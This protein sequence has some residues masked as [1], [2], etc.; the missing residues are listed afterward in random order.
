MS[1]EEKQTVRFQRANYMVSNLEQ[2]YKFYCDVLGFTLTFEKDSEPD[3]YSYDVFEIDK[4][5][6]M[7]FAILSTPSQPRAMALTEVTTPTLVS[8]PNPRRAA[9]VLDVADV[10]AVVNGAKSLGLKI[11]HED[12]L[13]THDGRQGRE[14]G[15]VDY[16][17]NLVVIYNIP[18]G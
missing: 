5:H 13:E 6:T 8:A 2:S 15:I 4:K 1:V 16:D 12:L 10:D 7:R 17:G 11:Y 9:I 14:V 3:S 18:K